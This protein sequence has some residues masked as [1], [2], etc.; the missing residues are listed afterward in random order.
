[1]CQDLAVA[2]KTLDV[3]RGSYRIVTLEGEVVRSSGAVTGGTQ[4]RQRQGGMLARERE[5]R[6]LPT[7]LQSMR[8][9]REALD[10]EIRQVVAEEQAL[11]DELAA[12]DARRKEL[13]AQRR[14]QEQG[15]AQIEQQVDRA[16]REGEWH[17]SL[18]ASAERELEG[19][20]AR[21]GDLRH[22]LGDV[23]GQIDATQ[24]EL[25]QLKGQIDREDVRS[26]DA[27]LAE[28]RAEL[29]FTRQ[30]E[31]RCEA[32]LRGYRQSRQ[33]IE[34]QISARERQLRELGEQLT[35]TE[36]RIEGLR[37]QESALGVDIQAYADRIGPAEGELSELEERQARLEKEEGQERIRVQD[38]E[39]RYSHTE[40][41]VARQED[42]MGSLRRQI[43]DDLGLVDLEMGED[44]SGQPLLPLGT[45]VS[46]L[47]EVDV[48]PEGVEEQIR[49]L[50]RRLY[51]LGSINPNAPQEYQ[52]IQQRHAF[53]SS[54]AQ[55]L[56]QATTQLREVIAELDQ[57]MNR[58]FR[59]TFNAVARE[60]RAF[61]PEL[62][63]GGSAR[64]VLTDPD[65]LMSTGIDIVA[66]PPGKRQQGLAVLSG[67]ERALTAAA[68]IFSILKVSP[69]PFCVLDEVDAALDEANVGRFR[70][71]LK[72]LAEHTQ[73]VVITHNRY[74][75]EFA[76]IV[77]GIS[78]GADGASCVISHRM[79]QEEGTP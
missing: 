37:G 49:A 53:L 22:K 42:H 51:R 58:E 29:A 48:L 34:T 36:R 3:V 63:D 77:Y 24:A 8:T 60:F 6:E 44:L 15:R 35:H 2:R 69:T 62:F 59:R 79:G 67:G 12:L 33:Q 45:F 4:R 73:F 55:D 10:G 76:D 64:L 56:E 40:L 71:V 65:D 30:L 78:M 47:P 66:R 57:V 38:L 50:K 68:L 18:I 39:S 31:A 21:E 11:N 27:Q 16:E 46:S 61:F 52:E 32:E 74:T 14:E 5:R 41:Q 1:V 72:A 43:Q 7:R 75:I 25:A 23:G 54:Q 17:H 70:N 20:T 13:E 28:R 26:L 9:Q 19:L